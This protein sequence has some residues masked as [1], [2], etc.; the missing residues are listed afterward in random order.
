MFTGKVLSLVFDL[1]ACTDPALLNFDDFGLMG[2]IRSCSLIWSWFSATGFSR[3]E[4]CTMLDRDG[5]ISAFGAGLD[6][7]LYGLLNVIILL[8]AT[9]N[10][11]FS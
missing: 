3:I 5:L 1:F 6:G 7:W 10:G 11:F 2:C 9:L 8:F 4:E